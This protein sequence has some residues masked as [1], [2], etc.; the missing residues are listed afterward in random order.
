MAYSD[1]APRGRFFSPSHGRGVFSNL[2]CFCIAVLACLSGC[3][4]AKPA[5]SWRFTFVSPSNAGGILTSDSS[6]ADGYWANVARGV[7]EASHDLNVS[8]NL[9]GSSSETD[10]TGML[11]ALETAIAAKV[12]GI[13]TMAA[14]PA[15][16][17]PLI[18]KAAAAGIPVVLL[19]TD[20]PSSRRIA[21]I[22]TDNYEAGRQAAH[23]M[24]DFTGGRARIGILSGPRD[25]QNLQDRVRGFRDGIKDDSGLRIV[26][27]RSGRSDLLTESALLQQM[28]DAHPD[29][30]AVLAADGVGAN[31]SALV[32][33]E[34]N[35]RGR[36]VVVGFDRSSLTTGNIKSGLVTAVVVRDGYKMGYDAIRILTEAKQEGRNSRK[37]EYIP[38]TVVTA[39][40]I[41]GPEK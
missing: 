7:R 12:D 29:I 23:A 9:M 28:L 33:N 30:G 32:V 2:L 39:G 8:T 24:I 21:Y 38:T 37:E 27:M 11:Q 19:D 14:D 26:D 36:L 3:T 13:V 6:D 18:D 22:G 10:V 40:T 16:F 5:A 35:L 20:A 4:K 15:A 25:A 1:T 34:R 41:S 17:A 31:A